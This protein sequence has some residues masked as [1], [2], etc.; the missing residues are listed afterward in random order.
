MDNDPLQ[1]AIDLIHSGQKQEAQKI[2]QSMLKVDVH[3]IPAWFWYIETCSTADQRFE[4]LEACAI[5]N[6]GSMQVKSALDA[7]KKQQART[8]ITPKTGTKPF[9]NGPKVT[10]N[11]SA[12]F[13][14]SSQITP[15][16]AAIEQNHERT[17]TTQ[18][19]IKK[20][21]SRAALSM[22]LIAGT[23]LVGFAILIVYVMNSMP[24]E[25]A[26]P[27]SHRFVRPI[28]YYLYVPKAYTPDHAWRLFIGIHGSGGTGLDCWNLWQPYAEKEGFI[29]LCPTLSDASGGWFQSAGENNTW[30]VISEVTGEYNIQ[31]HYFLVGFSA[32]AQF[33]QGFCFHYPSSVQ[34]VA[35]LSA[36]NYYPPSPQAGGIPFLIVIGDRDDPASINGSQQFA[37][38]LA[39]NGSGVNYWLLPGVGH[40]VTSKTKQL[41]IDFFHAANK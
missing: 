10:G 34:A 31:P 27:T 40:E 20:S 30:A 28:E 17:L 11:S 4:I 38:A 14:E 39:N 37:Q 1:T 9:E 8:S 36:G 25:P 35:V 22:W 26:D 13:A 19:P 29:L 21:V 18:Q 23:L 12:V 6:P 3:N 7:L 5:C 2:L 41:T 16:S 24:A 33:V 15:K 32:G